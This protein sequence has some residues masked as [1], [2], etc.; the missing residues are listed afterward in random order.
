MDRDPRP[1]SPD[2]AT[3][4]RRARRG[5]RAA[6]AQLVDRHRDDLVR[7]LTRLTGDRGRA[8]DAAQDAFLR[9]L[10]GRGHYRPERGVFRAYLFRAGTHAAIG[11]FRRRQRWQRLLPLLRNGTATRQEPGQVRHVQAH[12]TRERLRRALATLPLHY[13]SPL[14]LHAVDGWS[15]QEIAQALDCQIGTV[16]SRIFRARRQ[17]QEA[18]ES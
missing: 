3:L 16:K 15:Y 12:E 18:L 7:Y 9:L 2:D 8:E 1:P 10:E 4:Y 11:R 6:L 17:L 5:E 13:R 14:L